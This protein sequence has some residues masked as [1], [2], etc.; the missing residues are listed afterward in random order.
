MFTVSERWRALLAGV[1]FAG[2]LLAGAT[3]AA[4][5]AFDGGPESEWVPD[6]GVRPV[7]AVTPGSP[8]RF[9]V[10]K[11]LDELGEGDLGDVSAQAGSLFLSDK[12][13]PNELSGFNA[14]TGFTYYR[15][16][17][18]AKLEMNLNINKMQLGCGGVNDLL[19]GTPGCDIDID[20]MGLMG[21]NAAGDRPATT[22]PDSLFQMTRPFIELAVKNDGT[23]TQR[24]I[25]G[26]RIGAQK[27]NGAI[28]MGR[29]YLGIGYTAEPSMN[30]M[31][32][33]GVCNPAAT[34]G[35]GVINCHSGA[36]SL[37]G[38]LA[39]I[40]LSAGFL[41]RA[42]VCL[43]LTTICPWGIGEVDLDMDGCIGRIAFSPCTAGDNPFFI[44]AGGTRL[45][46]LW[47]AAAQ[48][49][50]KTN[51]VFPITLDG[52]G[53]L[54][55]NTRQI[56]YLIA[57]NSSDFFLSFQRERVS[58]PRYEKTPP[59]NN[60]AYDACNPAYGQ[61]TG[62]C[63]SAY[64]PPANTGW[65]LSAAN[66]KMLNLQP[67]NRI[68]IPGTFDIYTLLSALGPTS[69]I[70]IDNPR[71]DFIAADNCYGTARFC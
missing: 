42:R 16:G 13:S 68:V 34:T 53:Q 21:I 43:D 4:G 65:W 32:N 26:I 25:V 56:H 1:L 5:A 49:K 63:S 31:E 18:D 27:I 59:P 45:N 58:W 3:A 9:A 8:Q 24:E 28:R 54:I 15:M 48:L 11:H 40:E 69:G 52:Y 44:D 64:S 36:N 60:L 20:Y 22:G 51:F 47:V 12:I 66:L 35:T 38:Y 10:A 61:V 7:K 71:L 46:S 14:Y 39:G 2:T 19:V 67:G 29:D 23:R 55:L 6:D 70:V 62:R 33:G 41:A 50:L 17:L 37:S 57:P 30:N